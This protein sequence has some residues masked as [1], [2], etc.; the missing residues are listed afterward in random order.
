[1]FNFSSYNFYYDLP[2]N[3]WFMP[4]LTYPNYDFFN[5]NLFSNFQIPNFNMFTTN[6]V[7]TYYSQ[8]TSQYF[9]FNNN[10]YNNI[11]AFN[12]KQKENLDNNKIERSEQKTDF[13]K[14]KLSLD[15]Y[16][17][18]K[19]KKLADIA[20]K[21]STDWTGY[22]ASY[23]KSDI[24]EAGLGQ[25]KYGH[26]YKMTKILNNN[27]NFKQISP[28]T[29]VS[30]LP[31]GCILVYG[32]GVEGYD[33]KYGHTEITFIDKNT[34]KTKAVSDGITNNLYKK[35]TSIFIPV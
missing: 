15:G 21:N 34:G 22:C 16:N 18:A 28:D 25:Y 32:K 2:M 7:F 17:A 1:M 23:V 20:L 5:L 35:P 12:N 30:K 8:L 9:A 26:A 6:N 31:E 3:N 27:P 19:G 10:C 13:S 11:F 14:D 4:N 24:Q 29:N 33:K